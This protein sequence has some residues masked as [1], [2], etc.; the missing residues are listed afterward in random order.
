MN[1]II[2]RG[3]SFCQVDK[4]RAGNHA[5]EV[6]TDGYHMWQGAIPILIINATSN[7]IFISFII[8]WDSHIDILLTI[9]NLDPMAWTKRYFTE[10]SVS[11]KLFDELIIGI[12][13]IKF[14][15]IANQII[16]QLFLEMVIRVLIII[17]AIVIIK[18]G[19]YNIIKMRLGLH[20]QI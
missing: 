3:A 2:D 20:H 14:N 18:K 6:I 1:A 10:A 9:S 11:W 17:V 13:E 7:T 8:W 12:N 16:S 5:I 4:I 19:E 15:S